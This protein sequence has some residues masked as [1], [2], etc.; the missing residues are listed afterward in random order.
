LVN[1]ARSS[2]AKYSVTTQ[3]VKILFDVYCKHKGDEAPAYRVFVNDELFTERTWIWRDHYLEEML[4]IA[5][6]PGAYR[7]RIE[8]VK[9]MGGKFRCYN[10]RVEHGPAR[11][12]DDQTVEIQ[13]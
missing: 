5:A 13:P 7:I 11:W 1:P 4:Q 6:E 2:H 9:P 10:H 8:A 3:F 12:I